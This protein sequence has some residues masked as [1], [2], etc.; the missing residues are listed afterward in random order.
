[1]TIDKRLELQ[2]CTWSVSM[3]FQYGVKPPCA[4]IRVSMRRDMES[5]RPWIS[6]WGM[7]LHTVC[8]RVHKAS[9]VEAGGLW[10][11]SRRPT[12]SQTCSMGD[13]SGERASQRSSDTRLLWKN[14]CTILATC[15]R[16]LS[17]WNMACGVAWRRGSTSGCKTSLISGCC[18]DCP[19]YVGGEIAY[20]RPI[21]L[22]PKPLH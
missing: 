12:K 3:W 11:I 8:M 6:S 1:M 17:C 2:N 16:A 14:A 15:G 13:M 10:R 9:R 18:S 22:R 19:Q 7:S 5:K 21:Q 4:A 20:C